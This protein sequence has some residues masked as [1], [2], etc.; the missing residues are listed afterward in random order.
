MLF[1]TVFEKIEK[2]DQ[3]IFAE[4]IIFL[5]QCKITTVT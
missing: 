4:A 3:H 1:D 2:L 5:L